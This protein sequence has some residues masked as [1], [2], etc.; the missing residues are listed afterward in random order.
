[1]NSNFGSQQRGSCSSYRYN[2]YRNKINFRFYNENHCGV[3]SS[4]NRSTVLKVK[5]LPSLVEK[6]QS[7]KNW[8]IVQE[9]Q[10][11][12]KT[13]ERLHDIF[14][15]FYFLCQNNG[16]FWNVKIVKSMNQ[17]TLFFGIFSLMVQASWLK[18]KVN[19][20]FY[21]HPFSRRFFPLTER[22]QLCI[23]SK[24]RPPLEYP[25]HSIWSPI[26]HWPQ[27][28]LKMNQ[29]L[30][31][32]VIGYSVPEKIRGFGHGIFPQMFDIFDN[33]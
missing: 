23:Q 7:S 5:S 9:Q 24:H 31:M 28:D 17:V 21:L 10:Q 18:S 20:A 13:F 15:C 22:H 32:C 30:V 4:T 2:S 33:F 11:L 27:A 29:R 12:C 25:Q 1:M 26:P 14:S 6:A 8:K 16:K 3:V 19:N